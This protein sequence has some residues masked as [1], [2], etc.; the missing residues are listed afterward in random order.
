MKLTPVYLDFESFWSAEHSLSKMTNIEYVTHPDT[1]IISIALKIGNDAPTEVFFGEDEIAKALKTVDWSRSMAIGHNMSGFDALILKWRFDI[2]P[3]LWGCTLAMAR[4]K[5][6]AS[7]GGSLGKLVAYFKPELEAMGISGVKDQSALVNTK[8]KH[9]K[10]FTRE[11]LKAMKVYNKTDTEQCAGLFKLLAKDFPPK[12]LLQIDLTT[13]ML[14]DPQFEVDTDLLNNTL[15]K[16][17]EE[18]S[19]SLQE[20]TDMLMTKEAQVLHV[21]E[22]GHTL[23]KLTRTQLMSATKFSEI[24]Q[25]RQV[26]IPMKESPSVPGKF[27]PALSKT[28]QSFLDLQEHSDPIVRTAVMARLEAKSTLLETRINAFLEAAKHCYGFIPMPLRYAGAATTGRWSGEIFNCMPAGHEVLTPSGWEDISTWTPDRPIMQ[29]WPDG[30][31]DWCE[32]PG[33]VNYPFVGDLVELKGPFVSGLFTPGHRVP[34]VS[35]SNGVVTE[36]TAGWIAAHSGLD[37]VPAAGVFSGGGGSLTPEQVRLIVAT[38]ADGC[39]STGG[40]RWGFRKQRKIDRIQELLNLNGLQDVANVYDYRAQGN[41]HWLCI[42]PAAATPPWL[43]KGFGSWILSLSRGA[44]DAFVDELAYWDGMPHSVTGNTCFF[45]SKESQALWVSTAM[46]LSGIPARVGSRSDS[47]YDVYARSGKLSSTVGDYQHFEGEV[48]CPQVESSWFLVRYQG[49]IHVTGNCQNLP[50]IDPTKPKLT[51]ALRN[52]L[53]AP[54]GY[55]VVTSDLS[56]IELRVNHFLWKVESSMALFKADPAKADLYR[57]FAASLYQIALADVTKSQRQIG[58]IAHLGLGFG[59]GAATFQR[60]AKLMGGVN[61]GLEEATAVTDAW[62]SEYAPIKQGWRTCHDALKAISQ[63]VEVDIDPWGLCK[64]GKDHIALPSGRKIWYPNLH[65]ETTFDVSKGENKKEWVYGEGRNRA[66]IYAGKVDENI[67]QALARDV[68][69]EVVE[70]MWK[71]HKIKPALLVHDE[72]V[73]VVREEQADEARD[74]LDSIMRE[75]TSWW[76]E[77]IKWSESDMGDTYGETH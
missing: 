60:I 45:T 27:I 18:K 66:R 15:A 59:A 36:R 8:G 70:R 55:K 56:G 39:E 76:P 7:V 11:E 3:K 71:R 52:S 13:R 48:Y 21:L 22:H 67:V 43:R 47:K 5:Y 19:R 41:N 46:H 31:M 75:P 74:Q 64:T 20:L 61:M 62:R 32:M 65:V 35:P 28:D 42:L 30:H 53:R 6:N 1:E 26:P 73:L 58:K 25:A 54:K 34:R 68:L 72:V 77:L 33:K 63:G 49:S 40:I 37:G 69:A 4:S 10:D 57:Q 14:V 17:Q 23:D 9:L 24:L 38:S 50:R 51:D 16:V 2:T 12:E 29:W 44:L